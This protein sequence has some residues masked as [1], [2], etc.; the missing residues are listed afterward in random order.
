MGSFWRLPVDD[1]FSDCRPSQRTISRIQPEKDPQGIWYPEIGDG[2]LLGFSQED[3][4][5]LGK[6]VWRQETMSD[7]GST[8]TMLPDVR[9]CSE[10]LGHTPISRDP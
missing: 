5:A 3:F 2:E 6:T 4:A 1:L 8:H 10:L 7:A 9:G